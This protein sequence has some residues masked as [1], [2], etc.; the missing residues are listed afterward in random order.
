L[1]EG[2]KAET[3]L[4]FLDACRNNP[5]KKSWGNK[6]EIQRGFAIPRNPPGTCVVY[7]T[8]A[9]AT[10]DDNVASMNGLFT[11]NL[12]QYLSVPNMSLSSILNGTRKEVYKKS[13]KIQLPEDHVKLLGDFYFLVSSTDKPNPTPELVKKEEPA[14]VRSTPKK[15]LLPY[16]PEMVLVKGGTFNIGC[17][18]GGN[19]EKPLHRVRLEDFFIGKFEVTVKEYLAFCSATK[20]HYPEWLETGS[21]YHIDTGKDTFYKS[22]GYNRSSERLPIVG[23][24]WHDAVAYCQW[25]SSQTGKTYRLPTEA[26]WEFAARGGKDNNVNTFAGSNTAGSVGWN[27]NNS[28]GKPHKV[29]GKQANELGLYDMSGNVWEW[30]SDWYNES[31]YKNSVDYNPTGPKD[32]TLKVLRGGSCGSNAQ[33]SRVSNRNFNNLILRGSGY[34]FRVAI[35]P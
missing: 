22:K 17:N 13:D 8:S 1:M 35:E 29:G 27:D 6:G 28:E 26:E 24:S 2:S 3:N 15:D 10:A 12:L 9:G 23:I 4:V 34:G 30:C 16:E 31:Y 33:D 5:F 21:Q 7:A 25:L 14:P 19:D 18:D 20:S 32:G 11:E